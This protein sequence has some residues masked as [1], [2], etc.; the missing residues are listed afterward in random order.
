[1]PVLAIDYRL[2]PEHRYP[3]FPRFCSTP[4]HR[5]HPWR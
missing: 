5:C 4:H 2:A 3:P 1:V